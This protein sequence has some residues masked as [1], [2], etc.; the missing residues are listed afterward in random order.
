MFQYF[1]DLSWMGMDLYYSCF[2]LFFFKQKTAYE[3]RIS[4]WSSDVCSSDLARIW[5]S[6]IMRRV[7]NAPIV[8]AAG[9]MALGSPKASRRAQPPASCP[10]AP[11][12]RSPSSPTIAP[13]PY[14]CTAST[15][16]AS[17]R[18]ADSERPRSRH[19][20]L[21]NNKSRSYPPRHGVLHQATPVR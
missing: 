5:P 12:S 1:V 20:H 4:D 19:T 11:C 16:T 13:F 6:G 10:P 2:L 14:A 17:P 9:T 8:F 7:P 3:M 21:T 15:P 18:R